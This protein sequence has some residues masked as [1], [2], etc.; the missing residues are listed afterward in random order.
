MK[1]CYVLLA[2][3]RH[4]TLL[5]VGRLGSIQF[6]A[7][8]YAYVGSAMINLEKRIQRHLRR[9][10]RRHWHIDYLLEVAEPVAVFSVLSEERCECRLSRLIARLP[11]AVAIEGFG[12]SDCTCRSHLFHFATSPEKEIHLSLSRFS[13]ESNLTLIFDK[14]AE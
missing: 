11:G 7:G 12:S 8:Y 9:G 1:G 5:Q 13:M 2:R 3:L 10:K 4:E 6:P 14:F